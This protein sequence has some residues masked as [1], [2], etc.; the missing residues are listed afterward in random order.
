MTVV[1]DFYH[2]IDALICHS[3]IMNK[4]DFPLYENVVAVNIYH[5]K[6]WYKTETE[7]HQTC[8]VCLSG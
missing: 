5:A 2:Y 7:G 1:A 3:L 4:F 6:H 8:S